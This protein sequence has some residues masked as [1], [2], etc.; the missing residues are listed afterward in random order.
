MSSSPQTSTPLL[1]RQL[2]NKKLLPIEPITPP[3]NSR[4]SRR[5]DNQLNEST[6][7]RSITKRKHSINSTSPISTTSSI[8]MK[9]RVKQESPGRKSQGKSKRKESQTEEDQ[10]DDDQHTKTNG[11]KR[12]LSLD[13][14]S[15]IFRKKKQ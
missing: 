4:V 6:S 9:K 3:S 13:L 5:S 1:K 10:S 7:T 8:L 11:S 15:K 2:S 14:S 12:K